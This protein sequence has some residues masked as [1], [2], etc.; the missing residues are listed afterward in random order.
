MKLLLKFSFTLLVL[1]ICSAENTF[2][3]YTYGKNGFDTSI[4]AVRESFIPDF[5]KSY[6]DYL[7]YTPL[8]VTIGLKACGYESRSSW[9]RMLV[10]DVLSIGIMAVT[11]NGLKYTVQ[12]QRPDNSSRNSFPSGHTAIAFT[13]ATILHK[14]YGWRSP[15]FSIGGYS[16]AA[17]TGISRIMNKRHWLTDITAGAAIGIGS[18]HLGYFL[19][20]KIF[21]NKGIAEG[22]KAPVFFYDPYKKHYVAEVYFGYRTIIGSDRMKDI[23]DLPIR[24]GIVGLSADIPIVPGIG[25]TAKTSTN[26]MI[27][28]GGYSLPMYNVVAGGYWNLHFGKILEFQAHLMGGGVWL[29]KQSGIDLNVGVGLS[30]ITD[31]NFKVK[32]FADYESLGFNREHPWMNTISIGFGSAWFW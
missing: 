15:W 8:A 6:D 22:F 21:G 30:M 7:Q 25:I 5:D 29:N 32:I 11:V 27:Y 13:S 24:G 23:C 20:D 28:S 10:S 1:L 26:S 16:A 14:E 3:Q 18:A 17:I 19:S 12:R 2:A 9:N 31:R 4:Y